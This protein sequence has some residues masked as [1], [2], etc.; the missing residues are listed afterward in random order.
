MG[1]KSSKERQ[2]TDGRSDSSATNNSM[3]KM[4]AKPRTVS[5][6]TILGRQEITIYSSKNFNLPNSFTMEKPKVELGKLY[7]DRMFPLHVERSRWS[8]NLPSWKRPKVWSAKHCNF[9]FVHLLSFCLLSYLS[10]SVISTLPVANF[11]FH[12]HHFYVLRSTHHFLFYCKWG[13]IITGINPA[14]M[15]KDN[16]DSCFVFIFDSMWHDVDWSFPVAESA[17]TL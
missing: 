3:N 8:R 2:V 9:P 14:Y 17:F 12:F 6:G 16:P 5:N 15:V 1:A 10:Y 13:K 7:E 4:K 11:P